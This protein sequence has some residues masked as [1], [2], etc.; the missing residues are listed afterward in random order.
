MKNAIRDAERTHMHGLGQTDISIGKW[1]RQ[2]TCGSDLDQTSPLILS[3]ALSFH[4]M[5]LVLG[6]VDE[7]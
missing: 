7:T 6:A 3:N 5:T 2:M 1:D 4:P